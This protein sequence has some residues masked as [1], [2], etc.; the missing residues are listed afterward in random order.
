MQT[1]KPV[2]TLLRVIKPES[3][4]E[5]LARQRLRRPVTPHLSIYKWQ[6]PGARTATLTAPNGI[7]ILRPRSCDTGLCDL[8]LGPRV[9]DVSGSIWRIRCSS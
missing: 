2:T 4:Q 7:E 8:V 3:A 1:T 5:E 6:L 9:D